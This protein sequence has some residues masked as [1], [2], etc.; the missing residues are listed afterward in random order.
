MVKNL[1][2][3]AGAAREVGSISKEPGGLQPMGSQRVGQDWALV[4]NWWWFFS[5]LFSE[6]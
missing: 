5:A 4:S 2:V 6:E 3:N 1:P